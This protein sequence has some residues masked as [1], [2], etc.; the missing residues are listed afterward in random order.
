[1]VYVLAWISEHMTVLPSFMSQVICKVLL[2]AL[3][4]FNNYV[5]W[6]KGRWELE[7]FLGLFEIGTIK[8]KVPKEE[9]KV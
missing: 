5:V 3:Q 4:F 1:M 9:W 2:R 6:G 8:I 7:W